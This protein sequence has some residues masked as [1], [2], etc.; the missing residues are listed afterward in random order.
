MGPVLEPAARRPQIE[1]HLGEIPPELLDDTTYAACEYVDR[2]ASLLAFDLRRRLGLEELLG[3]GASVDEAL[4]AKRFV[5][6]FRPALAAL[7]ARLAA[8]GDEP[9][10]SLPP[11]E[12]LAELRA[13]ALARVPALAPS[14]ALLDAAAEVYPAV[15]SGELTGEQALLAPD[16]IALWL[17]YFHNSNPFYA[18]S[19]RIAAVA[20]ANRLPAAG[21]FSILEF[22]AGAGSAAAALLEELRRRDRLGDVALYDFTE[23]APF[24]RRRGERELRAVFPE[25]QFSFRALDLDRSFALQEVQGPF[26]LAYGVNVLHVAQRLE[27][28]LSELANVLR[29]GGALVVGECVRLF[30]GQSVPADLVF[31]LLK[32]FSAVELDP[33]S[34]PHHGFLEPAQWRRA[35]TIA[36]FAAV[37]VVPDLERIR[38]LYPR[39]FTGAICGRRPV[40]SG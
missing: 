16:R 28:T 15:A 27:S 17:A 14:L 34:R 10:P 30:S 21:R 1:L 4:A 9:S 11:G 37:E 20:A 12:A 36:G 29:P 18:L 19:N 22:G 26:D 40:E 3:H 8:A 33:D 6:D 13:R 39:F 7:V 38:D 25:V 24:F 5:T 31:Q 2:Y 35:L 32:A 23:P